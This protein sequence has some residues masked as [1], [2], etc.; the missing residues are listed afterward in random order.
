MLYTNHPIFHRPISKLA[1]GGAALSGQAGGYGFGEVGEGSAESLVKHAFEAGINIFD[2]APIYGFNTSE[3]RLGKYVKNFRDDILLVSKSGITWHNTKRVNL[4]N[5]AKTTQDMLHESLKNLQ[6]EYIDL[7]LIHW[8]DPRVDI[9]IPMEV[10]A[11]AKEKGKIRHIGLCNTNNDDL[12]LAKEIEEISVLQSECNLFQNQLENL[13]RNNEFLMGWGTLDKGILAG[14]VTAGR[15]FSAEDARSWAPW[16][17]KSNWREKVTKVADF[18]KE[19]KLD[20]FD[21]ALAYSL[22]NTSTSIAGFKNIDQLTRLLSALESSK[23]YKP[24]DYLEFF[25]A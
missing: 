18:Q 23:D 13:H 17:K 12:A 2:T 9:R 15:K 20:I 14:T 6:T 19:F 7:Y 4:T 1:L 24:E 8:P 10:L 3:I 25:R 21:V 16:W 11:K 5:D 22:N